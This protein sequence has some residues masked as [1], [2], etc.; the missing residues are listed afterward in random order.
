MLRY[1]LCTDHTRYRLGT[2]N[3]KRGGEKKKVKKGNCIYTMLVF[4]KMGEVAGRHLLSKGG[5][6]LN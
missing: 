5:R 6:R 4:K 2:S 3:I 1:I